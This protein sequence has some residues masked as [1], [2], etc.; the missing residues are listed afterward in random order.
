M[1]SDEY[2]DHWAK[3]FTERDLFKQRGICFETFLLAPR[4]IL[5][6]VEQMPRS[7]PLLSAQAAVMHRDLEESMVPDGAMLRGGVYVLPLKHH[8]YA[9]S[10]QH[11]NN[12]RV[13]A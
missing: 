13:P 10:D 2:I 1:Y 12:R 8:A 3:V 9:I 11:H 5:A 4:E 6:A 7:E